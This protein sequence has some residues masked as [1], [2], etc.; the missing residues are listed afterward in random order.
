MP[1]LLPWLDDTT[2]A[3]DFPSV[4]DVMEQPSG[5]LAA[6]GKL[7][8]EWLLTAYQRGIF[9]WYSPGEPLLWWS[10]DPRM[11]LFPDSLRITRSLK[12]RIRNGGF[13]VTI[14]HDFH[15]IIHACATGHDDGT[16]ITDDMMNA[17]IRLHQLGYAHSVEVW[18]EDSLVGGLYG[19][20]LGTVFFGESMFSRM[21]DASKVAFALFT[22]LLDLAG[23]DLID[24]QMHTPHLE[25]LGAEEI[26]RNAFCQQLTSSIRAV[27]MIEDQTEK[28]AFE[29]TAITQTHFASSR[30]AIAPSTS[31][32][33]T[34]YLELQPLIAALRSEKPSSWKADITPYRAQLGF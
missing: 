29:N 26:S 23:F 4:D 15:Q 8:P 9:P 33:G 27:P 3:P 14:D 34:N 20:A 17:Y 5:L 32:S 13:C 10:P 2:D 24:C 6:G 25:S 19:V 31:S 1:T 7:T 21:N 11:V 18:H 12:K 28:N 16:W 22:R 30:H